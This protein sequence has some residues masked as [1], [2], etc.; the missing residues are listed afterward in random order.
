MLHRLAVAMLAVAWSAHRRQ[1]TAGVIAAGPWILANALTG[2]V[3]GVTCFQWALRTTP[4]L[5]RLPAVTIALRR[6]ASPAHGEAV[7]GLEQVVRASLGR[8]FQ[9]G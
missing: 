5:P 7:D 2:P 1:L 8:L 9:A 6:A 3:L 4:A